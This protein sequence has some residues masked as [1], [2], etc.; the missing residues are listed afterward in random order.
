M[1]QEV[2]NDLE[3]ELSKDVVLFGRTSDCLHEIMSKFSH[4]WNRVSRYDRFFNRFLLFIY[5]L[6][7]PTAASVVY[8]IATP[9]VRNSPVLLVIAIFLTS[10]QLLVM[11]MIF[12]QAGNV[13]TRISRL[14]KYMISLLIR[15]GRNYPI[16]DRIVLQRTLKKISSNQFPI[17]MTCGTVIPLTS[18]TILEFIAGAVQMSLLVLS[19]SLFDTDV[20]KMKT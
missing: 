19:S 14:F 13:H 18:T 10:V 12:W 6:C 16:S 17:C 9:R 2:A 8:V 11:M 5:Y 7:P 4:V 1:I 15:Y 20:F 3:E